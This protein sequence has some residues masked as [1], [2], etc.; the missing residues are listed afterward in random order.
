MSEELKKPI[1][2]FLYTGLID[3]YRLL[4]WWAQH[5]RKPHIDLKIEIEALSYE[6][7]LLRPIKKGFWKQKQ[8]YDF[9]RVQEQAS[10]Y[11]LTLINEGVSVDS[12]I[13]DGIKMR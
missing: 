8:C 5:G 9:Q 10:L 11:V 4:Q 7:L 1:Y 12:G 2:K 6:S 13:V 3:R